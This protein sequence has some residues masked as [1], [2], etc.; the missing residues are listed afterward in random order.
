M[1]SLRRRTARRSR[2]P[3][4]VLAGRLYVRFVYDSEGMNCISALDD[5]CRFYP[6]VQAV[7]E[8][9]IHEGT[10]PLHARTAR[11]SA[12]ERP[13][14]ERGIAGPGGELR[15]ARCAAWLLRFG[16]GIRI[17]PRGRHVLGAVCL[18]P[19]ARARRGEHDGLQRVEPD[20]AHGV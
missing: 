1:R 6:Q 10:E 18:V 11:F 3:E 15:K 5:I 7:E 16:L 20:R 17:G 8:I 12:I 14:L 13:E 4:L 19:C 2:R 9:R